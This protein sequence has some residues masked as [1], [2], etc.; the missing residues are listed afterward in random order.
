MDIE[1]NKTNKP[2]YGKPYVKVNPKEQILEICKQFMTSTDSRIVPEIEVRFGTK[3]FRQ[4]TKIDFDNVIKKLKSLGF[5]ARNPQGTTSL[6]IEPEFLDI[7]TGR[8]KTSNI[9]VEINGLHEIQSYCRTN[10]LQSLVNSTSVNFIKKGPIIVNEEIIRSAD[11]D[12]FNFRV[13][14]SGEETISKRSKIGQE[15]IDSWPG[16]KKSF[17]FINRV[18][19]VKEGLPFTVDMSIVKSSSRNEKGFLLK[20]NDTLESN[21]FNNQ[22][23]YEIEIEV[24]NSNAKIMYGTPQQ[25]VKGIELVSK[26]VL[27]GLQRTN[28]PISYKEQNF[29][30]QEYMKITQKE[31][32]NPAKRIYPSNFIGPSSVTLQTKNIA[33]I[34]PD[35]HIPNVRKDYVVTEKADGERNLL[36]ISYEGKIYLINSSMSVMFTGT[37]TN[38]KKYFN[39][40]LDGEL[41]LHD[42]NGKFINL[43][44]SFDIYFIDGQDIRALPFMPTEVVKKPETTRFTILKQLVTELGIVSIT[45]K[46]ES[47]L[48]P[49]KINTKRFYPIYN[50]TE[51]AS[52]KNIFEACNYILKN[53][54]DG[55]YEYNTDGLI[56]THMLFGVGSDKPGHTSPVKTWEYSFKW[57]PA[58]YNTIDFLISTK[59]TATGDDVVTPIFESGLNT[60]LV[61]QFTQYKTLIL[62]CGFDENR[63]G[64]I[65]PCQ[66]VLDDKVP[67]FKETEQKDKRRP[68]QFFPSI[69]YDPTAGLCNI[70]LEEAENRSFQMFTEEREVFTDNTI[71]EFRYDMNRDGL[72]RWI[73]LRV[74]YD[75]TAEYKR[76]IENYGNDYTTAN[77]NWYSIHNPVTKEM[78]TRGENIPNELANDDIYYNRITNSNDTKGLRDFHNLFVKKTLIQKVA[79]RGNTLIDYACG[80]GGDFPKWISANLSFVFGI[81]LSKDN[82]ENR[83]NGA[84]ARF[85][86]Y[87]KEFKHMPSALFVNGNSALNVRSGEAMLSD[88]AIQITKAVFGNGNKEKLDI[89][90]KKLFGKGE[91]GFDISSCQFAIHYMFENAK[92]LHNFIRNISECTKVGGY[93]IGTSYDGKTIFNKLKKKSIGEDISIYENGKKIWQM[94]KEYDNAVIEDTESSIGYKISVYQESI[95]KVI[96]EYLVNYDYLNRIME[97]YGFVVL[98][99][100][101]AKQI[102]LPEG[103]GMFVELYNQMLYEIKK[104]PLKENEYGEALKMYP[105]E[106]EI[107]FLNRYFVYKKIRNVDA[108]KIANSFIN[109]SRDELEL[110][111]QSTQIAKKATQ[112]VLNEKK[113]RVKKLKTKLVLIEASAS[114]EGEI[115]QEQEQEQE[116]RE[117]QPDKEKETEPQ[118]N[119]VPEN[120][121]K[122]KSTTTTKK[123]KKNRNAVNFEIVPN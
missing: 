1:Q 13:T 19:F 86:N 25:M 42:K 6:K 102:G 53:I 36:F 32:Y 121:P 104:N 68:M 61:A 3:G 71:V 12:D 46:S 75:K 70:I 38:E 72:W 98:P 105:Y 109:I 78:I 62:Q 55:K 14:Y 60:G 54:E 91:D 57:K 47:T 40:I 69:P 51:K 43:Y 100:D 90:V 22:E 9:R 117:N 106:K 2:G 11:F 29:I 26:Y 123:T 76:G 122:T 108:Y 18:F 113:T 45:N 52:D 58:E 96:P 24:I 10:D 94:I 80:K 23:N 7:R 118:V 116:E 115:E 8:F 85:L 89:G 21:V 5:I 107:S 74:R 63:H 99:R 28:Y 77:N 67:N 97:D 15:I 93:F 73:P 101:D 111:T 110:Q 30:L 31:K 56:F 87:K 81:D 82:L 92:T 34:N 50:P 17:R 44:A 59:K 84:C 66:D 65:N 41:I 48:I 37:K 83:I 20:T 88:K 49:L 27:C 33:P 120:K 16:T 39:S 79:N 4:I 114:P 119:V 95:N 112:D 103:S 64:Y 35:V